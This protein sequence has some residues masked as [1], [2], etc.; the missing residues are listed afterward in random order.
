VTIKKGAEIIDRGKEE[1][2]KSIVEKVFHIAKPEQ[3]PIV[4]T[5]SQKEKA[6]EAVESEKPEAELINED[7]LAAGKVS[8]KST[9]TEMIGEKTPISQ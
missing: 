4:E 6:A 5:V 2:S 1:V 9:P 3:Q 7:L 8:V